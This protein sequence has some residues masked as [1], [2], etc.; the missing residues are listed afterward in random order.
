MN[1]LKWTAFLL[2]SLFITAF[3]AK[4]NAQLPQELTG[5]YLDQEDQLVVLHRDFFYL[6]GVLS[7]SGYYQ[8]VQQMA[9]DEWTAYVRQYP[10][11]TNLISLVLRPNTEGMEMIIKEYSE[12]QFSLRPF[13][14]QAASAELP[15]T[16]GNWYCGKRDQIVEVSPTGIKLGEE[17]FEVAGAI[18]LIKDQ[19]LKKYFLLE[20]NGKTQFLPKPIVLNQNYFGWNLLDRLYEHCRK[21]KSWPYSDSDFYDELPVNLVGNWE[22]S[23]KEKANISFYPSYRF[24]L[25]KEVTKINRITHLKTKGTVHFEAEL[26]GDRILW[27]ITP[28]SDE[29]LKI[30]DLS[31]KEVT[32]YLRTSYVA[33]FVDIPE[34][35]LY[36]EIEVEKVP[37]FAFVIGIALG[38]IIAILVILRTR[39]RSKRQKKDFV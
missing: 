17:D 38:L 20:G 26:N 5:Y 30:T 37:V 10:D 24:S 9:E 16:A 29:E 31:T 33:D 36:D 22:A 39:R 6:E 7:K 15:F 27:E 4:A 8:D 34:E 35:E 12:K 13:E 3:S 25:A 21:D 11:Q 18:Q 23:P 14:P 2:S 1:R 28:I 32:N 19:K